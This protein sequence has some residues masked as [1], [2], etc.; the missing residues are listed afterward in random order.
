MAKN[1]N[2]ITIILVITFLIF[3]NHI[4]IITHSISE[5]P[6]K[7][8]YQLLVAF[9]LMGSDKLGPD[10]LIKIIANITKALNV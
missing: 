5:Q 4:L 3:I 8:L 7:M 9:I 2:Y 1:N 10:R 6:L